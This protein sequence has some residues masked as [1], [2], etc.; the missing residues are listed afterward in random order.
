M[1]RN[2]R[3][4]LQWE[5]LEQRA[6]LSGTHAHIHAQAQHQIHMSQAAAVS[7]RASAVGATAPT[8]STVGLKVGP[9]LSDADIQALAGVASANNREMFLT[10]LAL[11][12]T[13]TA[14]VS[15][16]SQTLL[17]DSRDID[18]LINSFA[19]SKA[20]FVPSDIMTSDLTIAD[21]V[22]AKVNTTDFV[23]TYLNAL[24]QGET[25][26]V[27]QLKQQ[28][29]AVQNADLKALF[30]T[31]LPVAQAHLTAEQA[32]LNG[33]SGGT[34]GGTTPSSSTL[35]SSD[36]QTL[37]QSYSA[38]LTEHFLAQ[39]T[40]LQTSN[41]NVEKYA[42]K[43]LADH[44]HEDLQVGMYA[45]ASGTFLPAN[46]QGM[47]VQTAQHVTSAANRS[48]Y[49]GV[50]LRQMVR[51]HTMDISSNQQTLATTS[52]ETLRQFAMDDIPTDYVHRQGA[53]LLLLSG[54]GRRRN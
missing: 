27:N 14:N 39:L 18:L 9:A 25:Q 40:L 15:Q 50:Y 26:Q 36:L 20:A 35:S 44:E 43:L 16:T 7:G 52:N 47:D 24:V 31:I 13:T 21:Q 42:E 34:A 37:E 45:A 1:R 19:Q 29:S 5:S 11:L 8:G 49:N 23:S 3:R 12:S 33:G 41:P 10:Q 51:S 32:L 4:D 30:Q 6:L 38:T 17:N 53:Q 28:S 22:L 46:L 54:Q 2:S 48:G